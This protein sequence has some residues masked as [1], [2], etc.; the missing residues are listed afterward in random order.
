MCEDFSSSQLYELII[1]VLLAWLAR[2]AATYND[3]HNKKNPSS[4]GI[5]IT[6]LA[7][8]NLRSH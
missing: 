7:V 1:E 6:P 2:A 3:Y 4:R 5:R 8:I